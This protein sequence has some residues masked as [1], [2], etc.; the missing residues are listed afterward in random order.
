MAMAGQWN[1]RG[2]GRYAVDLDGRAIG[3]VGVM[4][5]DEPDPIELTWTLWDAASEGLGY[6]SEAARAVLESWSGA[7]LV[8]RIMPGNTRSVSVARRLGF[9]HDNSVAGP[10]FAAELMTYRLEVA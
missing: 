8:A 1:L 10:D 2:Y 6:A 7:A 9:A 5:M 4:H 3:H